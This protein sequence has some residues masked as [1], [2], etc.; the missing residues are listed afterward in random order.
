[1]GLGSAQVERDGQLVYAMRVS[2]A[3]TFDE[4]WNDPRFAYKKPRQGSNYEDTCGDNVY[5][6]YDETGSWIQEKCFHG[7]GDLAEDTNTD[8]VLVGT[9][10]VY[11]GGSAMDL[12]VEFLARGEDY[13]CRFRNHQVHNLPTNLKDDVI[14]WLESM[15]R[16][17]GRLG[18]PAE[19]REIT[20]SAAVKATDSC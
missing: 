1:M 19:R 3:L 2:E 14:E 17:G 13:F 5:R 11:Y 16:D 8:R 7:D 10:F 20:G 15:C 12:P 4:Y 18:E 9:E 6:W